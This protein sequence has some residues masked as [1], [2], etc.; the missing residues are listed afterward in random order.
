[1]KIR[2]YPK[3]PL[4]SL[5]KGNQDG[6]PIDTLTGPKFAEEL[7]KVQEAMF[8]ERLD[9]LLKDIG[10]Q[11][12]KMLNGYNIKDL[13]RYKEMVKKYLKE[14]MERMYKL[15]EQAG[16]DRRGRHKIYSIIEVVDK[17]LEELTGLFMAEQKDSIQILKKLDEIKG[18]LLDVYS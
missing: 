14:A 15:K 12:K 11:S 16:W 1:M 5:G 18:L 7:G 6:R 3:A 8:Q 13:V 17:E 9:N 4:S 2:D 10:E